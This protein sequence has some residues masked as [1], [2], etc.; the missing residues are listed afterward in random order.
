[1]TKNELA[2]L[3]KS[4]LTKHSTFNNNVFMFLAC[5]EEHLEHARVYSRVV[6]LSE[7]LQ[8]IRNSQLLNKNIC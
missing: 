5:F 4:G 6:D 1:M 2:N 7:V 8:T 3:N